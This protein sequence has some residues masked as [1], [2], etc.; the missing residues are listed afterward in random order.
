M[1]ILTANNLSQHFGGFTVFTNVHV[2]IPHGARIGLVGPNGIGKTTLLLILSGL[3]EASYGTVSMANGIRL[4]Y[5][6]QEAMQA[7]SDKTHSVMDEM[8]S[9]FSGIQA[10]ED[11]MRELESLMGDPEA[12]FDAVM[13]EYSQIQEDFERIG[14]YDYE[15]RIQ[16]TL[17]GLGFHEAEYDLPLDHLSGGQKTRALLARLLLERPHLLIL[18]EPTN[19]LDVNAIEWLEKTLNSWDGA[20][21]IVSHDRFFLDRVAT[22]IWEMSREGVEVYRG[23]YSAYVQQRDERYEYHMKLY[24]QERERLL[25]ELDYIKRNIARASTNGMAVGR[26]RRLSRDLAGIEQMGLAA[27]MASSSWSETG[28]GNVRPLTVAEADKAIK[29]IP[30]PIKRNP[31]LNLKLK[32][33]QRSGEIVFK[34]RDLEVGYPG[35]FLFTS[36]DIRLERGEIAALI[37]GNGTGKTT[38]LKTITEVIEPLAGKVYPGMNLKIGYFAQAH[39]GL[40]L[41]NTVIDELIRY[42][43][44]MPSDARTYLAQYLFRGDDVFKKV[45]ELSG[46]ERAKLAMALLA[47]EGANFLLL[48]EPT[49][50]LDIAAQEVLQEVLEQFEGTILLVTHDRYIVN[51]LA[52]QIWHVENEHL[53]VFNGTYQEYLDLR[54]KEKAE[55]KV[56][57]AQVKR[58]EREEKIAPKRPSADVVKLEAQIHSLETSMSEL[59]TLIERAK[60]GADVAMLSQQYAESQAKLDGLLAQ[61]EMVAEKA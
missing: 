61:W 47:L 25:N 12:D 58:Q 57:R 51:R 31:K 24:E 21:L 55:A 43:A 30:K 27:Y 13:E 22:V 2:N 20:L 8:L 16:Q 56:Y 36:D 40:N 17:G 54:E 33:M 49:N 50:H 60:S 32:Y 1:A 26:L 15:V 3:A 44:M 45:G 52:T 7:F 39:D 11:R 34:T 38:M 35:K 10:Q 48:D 14:G 28:I 42:K 18:D 46:G 4:G 5:L 37:G 6:R 29:A 19:H 23:N 41:E 59:S 9:V 53:R